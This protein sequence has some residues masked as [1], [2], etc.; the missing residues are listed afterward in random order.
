MALSPRAVFPTLR[1]LISIR[2]DVRNLEFGQI[3]L[4]AGLSACVLPASGSVRACANISSK[5]ENYANGAEVCRFHQECALLRVEFSLQQGSA[6][7]R[8]SF[9]LSAVVEPGAHFHS[10]ISGR[11][12]N[13]PRWK[14]SRRLSAPRPWSRRLS[15]LRR[16][17]P[18]SDR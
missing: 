11:R 13:R 5:A 3:I 8:I 18:R 7:G 10:P 17:S 15:A 6:L 14:L 4:T 16:I 12:V 1:M 2:S 9:A